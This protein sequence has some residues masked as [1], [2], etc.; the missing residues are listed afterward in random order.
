MNDATHEQL[1]ALLDGELPRDQLRFLLRRLDGDAELAQRWSRYQVVSAVLRREQAAL[2]LRPDFA[3]GV[4]QRLDGEIAAA[5]SQRLGMR[6]LRWAAGGA[7][8]A[9]V[10]V[11]ALL[12]SRPADNGGNPAA[13]P[14]VAATAPAPAASSAP[15]GELRQPLLPQVLAPADFT[16]PASFESIIPSYA[17]TPRAT[18]SAGDGFVPYVLVVGPRQPALQQPAREAAPAQQ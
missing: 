10:A 17:V 8:A 15:V 7:I 3:A 2:R 4:L 12:A 9:S 1:S 18:Q 6:V 14:M 11:V 16:Q 5:T 13:A